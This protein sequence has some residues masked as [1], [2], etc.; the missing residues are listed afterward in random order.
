MVAAPRSYSPS[1]QKPAL[2]VADLLAHG[3]PLAIEPPVPVSEADLHRAHDPEHVAAVLALRRDNGFG[4]RSADVARSLVHTSGAMLSAARRALRDRVAFAPCSGFHHAG[5]ASC[6]GYCTF[7]GLAVAAL[8]LLESG[9]ARRVAILDCDMHYG[10]GT[11]QILARLGRPAAISHFTAGE[12][13]H[14]PSQASSFFGWLDDALAACRGAD[15]VLYQAGA[16]PHVDDPLGGFLSTE[17]LRERDA[18]VFEA[19]AASAVPVAWNLAGGYRRR[20]D[21]SIP[22]VLEVHRNTALECVRAY[23]AVPVESTPHA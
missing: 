13:F 19:L 8:A 11:D 20:P 7:N 6:R 1:A 4:D 15:V 14:D 5:W 16:D 18:C 23:G 3:L 22:D 2:V 17:Q 12:R 9:E 21:G 10:D